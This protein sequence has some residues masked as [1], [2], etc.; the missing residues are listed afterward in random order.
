MIDGTTAL[1]CLLIMQTQKYLDDGEIRKKP[2]L[3]ALIVGVIYELLGF[4]FT[5][6]ARNK[7]V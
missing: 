6:L 5:F 4:T 7:L 3:K 1:S 2:F